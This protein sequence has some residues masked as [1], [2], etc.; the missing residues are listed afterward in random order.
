MIFCWQFFL[1]SPLPSCPLAPTLLLQVHSESA[2]RAAAW[3]RAASQS[4]SVF[5][6]QTKEECFAQCSPTA[7]HYGRILCSI[8]KQH[9]RYIL[10]SSQALRLSPSWDI[11]KSGKWQHCQLGCLQRNSYKNKITLLRIHSSQFIGF[12]QR[13]CLDVQMSS[14]FHFQHFSRQ[15]EKCNSSAVSSKTVTLR[16]AIYF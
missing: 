13:K 1:L 16:I 10:W 3:V 6:R 2:I 15:T 14:N 11:L 12:P 4:S 8:V 5:D 7:W 9:R